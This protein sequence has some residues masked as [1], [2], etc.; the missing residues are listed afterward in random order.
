MFRKIYSEIVN[1]FT[2]FIFNGFTVSYF[3]KKGASQMF[4]RVLNIPLPNNLL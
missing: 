3:R 4:D 2:V 1:V